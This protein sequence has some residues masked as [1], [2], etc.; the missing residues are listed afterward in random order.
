MKQTPIFASCAVSSASRLTRLM[1]LF[2]YGLFAL[3]S[4][5]IAALFITCATD[6]LLSE[7]VLPTLLDLLMDFIQILLIPIGAWSLIAFAYFRGESASVIRR[8]FGLYLGSLF[9][10][11]ICN[12][13]ASLTFNG[14]LYLEEDI[15]YA[16]WYL[17]L[18]LILAMALFFIV[19]AQGMRHRRRMATAEAPIPVYPFQKLYDKNNPLHRCILGLGIIFSSIQI[20]Q[21]ILYDIVYSIEAESLPAPSDIPVMIAYYLYDIAFA[22]AFYFLAR[23]LLRVL[24]AKAKK[25]EEEEA[26]EE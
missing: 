25:D 2:T 17:L 1:L 7:T 19:R 11:R 8:L 26:L 4:L 23:L 21:R 16:G 14:A 13:A 18:D 15:I 3:N 5:G 22:F 6:V 24:F 20:L 9:F 12:M 10:C